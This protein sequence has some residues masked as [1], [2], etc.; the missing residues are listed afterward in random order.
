MYNWFSA[1]RHCSRQNAVKIVGTQCEKHVGAI[2]CNV[3]VC[4]TL[5]L[6]TFLGISFGRT[7]TFCIS[8]SRGW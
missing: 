2:C 8:N 4:F 5:D 6:L 7:V 3:K 1:V